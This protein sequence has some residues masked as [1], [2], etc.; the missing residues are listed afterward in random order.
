[1]DISKPQ[2]GIH[3]EESHQIDVEAKTTQVE[4]KLFALKRL[5]NDFI[6]IY[7]AFY[8]NQVRTNIGLAD[9]LRHS[10]FVHLIYMG[11]TGPCDSSKIIFGNHVYS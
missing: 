4:C 9:T 7:L 5:R 10:S 11:D 3:A 6:K 8:Y 2:A 1:M